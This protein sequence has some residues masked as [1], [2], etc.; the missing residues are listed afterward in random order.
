[1]ITVRPGSR[2]GT[3]VDYVTLFEE[4]PFDR[5]QRLKAGVPAT[6]L[7][8]LAAA[9]GIPRQKLFGWVG[10]SSATA[11]R[12]LRADAVLSMSEGERLLGVMRLIG[13]VEKIVVESGN[14]ENFDAARWAAR[15]LDRPNA[16]LG[17]RSPGE[18]VDTEDGRQIV[19]SLIS[20]MQSGAYS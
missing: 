12:R 1:M 4:T 14:P 8:E 15:W 10:M 7:S 13:L 20:R 6:Q 2:T 19:A 16:A 9:M 17:G 11:K 3:H 18:F 5:I